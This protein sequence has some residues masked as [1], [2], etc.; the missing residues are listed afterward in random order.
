MMRRLATSAVA[1]GALTAAASARA[2]EDAILRVLSDTADVHTGPGSGYRVVYQAQNGETLIAVSR[3]T[4][5]HWFQVQLP[6]GTYGWILGDEVLPLEV[7]LGREPR[8][9]SIW[10]QIGDVVFSPAPLPGGAVSL[11]FS[12]GVLGGEGLFLFRP[13]LL[14]EPHVSIEAYLGETVGD[15]LDI[16]HYGGG[17]NAFLWPRSPVTPFVSLAGGGAWGRKKADQFTAKPGHFATL[18]AGG[19]L[20][21]ALKKRVTVRT[22]VRHYVLYDPDHSYTAREYSGGLCVVF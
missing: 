19:G 5:D 20:I 6:D 9:P 4:G 14:V 22:D 15:Q 10:R 1:L 7:D 11:T 12:A 3:A 21:V 17:A 13:A 18:A 8:P 16:I 2:E